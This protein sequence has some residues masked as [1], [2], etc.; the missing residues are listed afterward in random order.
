VEELA[1]V[2]GLP[3]LEFTPAAG[4]GVP[5]LAPGAAL[6]I[7]LQGTPVGYL[8][9][10]PAPLL[11]K[12]VERGH[13]VWF[14]LRAAPLQAEPYPAVE[15]RPPPVYPGSWQDFTFV[16]PVRRGHAEL[17]AVL[18]EFGHRVLVSRA[19]VGSYRAKASEVANYTFRFSL[20]LPDRT[21]SAEDIQ[22]FRDAFL[23]FIARRELR[24]V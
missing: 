2:G 1:A 17:S 7:A 12:V 6:S 22:D 8:G 23:A 21:L 18:D 20:R 24:L 16:W 10:L 4:N 14:T 15:Y 11:G 9:L 3:P 5:W 19:F 13:A